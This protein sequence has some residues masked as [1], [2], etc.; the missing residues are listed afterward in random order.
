MI[1]SFK[2]YCNYKIKFKYYPRREG[3]LDKIY[4]DNKKAKKIFNW[5][6]KKDL[7]EI[8]ISTYNYYKK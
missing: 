3:D 4:T 5:K 1:K 6:P 8:A 2:K 7:K